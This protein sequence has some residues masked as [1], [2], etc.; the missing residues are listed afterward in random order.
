MNGLMNFC[1][2]SPLEMAS[3]PFFKATLVLISS[4]SEAKIPFTAHQRRVLYISLSFNSYPQKSSQPQ[5]HNLHL[6]RSPWK[7]YLNNQ[8]LAGCRSIWP[9]L[10]ACHTM[11]SGSSFCKACKG[12]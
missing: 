4:S 10:P 7:W 1:I 11:A 2:M 6:H 8:A 12:I 9:H 3:S 5:A